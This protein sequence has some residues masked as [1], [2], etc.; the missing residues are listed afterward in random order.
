M[1]YLFIVF[2]AE[3]EDDANC[4]QERASEAAALWL[5][6]ARGIQALGSNVGRE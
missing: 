3:V 6:M 1:L 5:R 4:Q 2:T